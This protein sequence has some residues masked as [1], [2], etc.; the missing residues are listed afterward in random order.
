MSNSEI[1]VL[2]VNDDPDLLT[3]VSTRLEREHNRLTVRTAHSAADGREIFEMGD[4]DCILSDYHMPV[5]TGVDLLRSVREQDREIPFILFTETG[6]EAVASESISAGVTDYVIQDTIGNQSELLARKICSYVD[7]RRQNQQ[8]AYENAQLQEL[9]ENTD[10]A[11]WVFSADWGTVRFVNAAYERIFGHPVSEL[12]ENPQSFV[13]RIAAEDRDR[14]QQAMKRA[15]DGHSVQIEYRVNKSDAL[16][17][18]V[19]SRCK[20]ITDAKGDVDFI[21]GFTRDITERKLHDQQLVEKNA[22]L[23]QFTSTVAHDLRNPLNV[24]DGY[25]DLAREAHDSPY[26]KTAAGAL[27]RMNTLINELLT[28]AKEG[29]VLKDRRK[30]TLSEL[31][32]TSSQN[33]LMPEATLEIRDS[34][35]IRCDPARTIEAIE[36]IL[37]N[38]IEHGGPSVTI[39]AGMLEDGTGFY[40]EDTGPGIPDVERTVVFDRG[41]SNSAHG[42]GFGLA[43]V[44]QVV[45]AHEWEIRVTEGAHGGARFEISDVEIID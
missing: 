19:E 26:L 32:Q 39:I 41:Y 34:K 27:S 23:E 20:P 24:A 3:L 36:N 29:A 8:I 40:I 6:D 33:I 31:V 37:R 35:Q 5:E 43:I 21:V 15:S 2:Y 45:D 13:H 1:I 17:L 14:I 38:A 44:K 9:S 11:L 7:T 4:I 16:Q 25:I 22:Q 10:D 42:T 18:W 12:Q 28:L 30:I